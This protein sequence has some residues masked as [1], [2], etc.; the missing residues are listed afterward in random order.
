MS[1]DM[2]AVNLPAALYQRLERLAALTGRPVETLVAQTLSAGLP[3]P[4]R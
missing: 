3:P 1:A 2:V 4:A